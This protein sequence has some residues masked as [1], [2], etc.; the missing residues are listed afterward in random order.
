MVCRELLAR[1]MVDVY[2]HFN[3]NR[4]LLVLS[5]EWYH[6]DLD[7]RLPRE[8]WYQLFLQW[9]DTMAQAEGIGGL[10]YGSVCSW[11]MQPWP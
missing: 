1:R 9:L 4:I 11:A 3:Y 6:I 2:P 7:P 10:S 5:E 8:H